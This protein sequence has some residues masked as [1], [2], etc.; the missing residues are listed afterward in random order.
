MNAKAAQQRL[1]PPPTSDETNA[2][3]RRLLLSDG[4][5]H[6]KGYVLAFVFMGTTTDDGGRSIALKIEEGVV[7]ANGREIG[8]VAPLF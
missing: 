2:V 1:G 7:S 8:R 4:R 6:W 5:K 3:L